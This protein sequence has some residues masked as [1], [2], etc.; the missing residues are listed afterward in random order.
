MNPKVNSAKRPEDFEVAS[1]K[2]PDSFAPITLQTDKV[3]E[4]ISAAP[5]AKRSV[6]VEAAPVGDLLS[7]PYPLHTSKRS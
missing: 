7:R 5:S 4:S 1:A 3:L 2:A 6:D